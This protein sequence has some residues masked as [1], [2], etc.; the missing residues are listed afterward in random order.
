MSSSTVERQICGLVVAVLLV[1]TIWWA[2]IDWEC[3]T[4][5]QFHFKGKIIRQ[6]EQYENRQK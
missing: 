1:A 4:C 6:L 5:C 2:Y 3:N